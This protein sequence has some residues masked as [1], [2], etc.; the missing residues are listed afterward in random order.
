MTG[1]IA[2]YSIRWVN[3]KCHQRVLVEFSI[4]R[5]IASDRPSSFQLKYVVLAFY[6]CRYFARRNFLVMH[7]LFLEQLS[8]LVF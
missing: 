7:E 3:N 6:F 1:L 5:N 8:I 4:G 2:M